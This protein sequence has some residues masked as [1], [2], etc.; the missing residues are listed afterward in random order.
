PAL[1]VPILG[2]AVWWVDFK[3][4]FSLSEGW[5]NVLILLVTILN[6]GKLIQVP[7]TFLA[8][9]IANILI[10]VQL[11]L[12][13]RKKD[14][15]VLYHILTL[16]FVNGGVA[17]VFH[18][19]SIFAPLLL[20]FLFSVIVAISLIFLQQENRY[21]QNNA[22]LKPAFGGGEKIERVT[23][24]HL[25]VLAART[26]VGF[27]LMLVLGYRWKRWIERGRRSKDKSPSAKPTAEP[28]VSK[29]ATR[30]PLVGQAPNF[31][32]A[33]APS[34]RL[35]VSVRY[36][37]GLF[38]G[39]LGSLIL[40]VLIF[41]T[42]PRFPEIEIGQIRFGHDQ[43]QGT[44]A[45]VRSVSGFN[46]QVRLGEIGPSADNF[47][48]VMTIRF[49]DQE[50]DQRQVLP[51]KAFFYLRGT[52]LVRYEDRSWFA[53]TSVSD[54]PPGSGLIPHTGKWPVRGQ[55]GRPKTEG[56]QEAM[57]GPGYLFSGKKDTIGYAL[58]DRRNG[59]VREEI[60]MFPLST[61]ILFTVWP[62]FQIGRTFGR[63]EDGRVVSVSRDPNRQI[64][65]TYYTNAFSSEGQIDL[66]PYQEETDRLLE[67]A[68]SYDAEKFPALS[69]LAVRWDQQSGLSTEQVV[70]RAKNLEYLLRSSGEYRYVRSGVQ[71][72]AD[73]DPL[74]DFATVHRQGHCEYFAG[75][76]ALMLRA[77]GIPSRVIVGF[78]SQY[79][80][81]SE[82][83]STVR[84]SD[85]HTWVEAYIP[86]SAIPEGTYDPT[87]EQE[88]QWWSQGGWLRLDAVPAAESMKTVRSLAVRWGTFRDSFRSFWNDCILNY[89]HERQSRLV[90]QPAGD[91]FLFLREKAAQITKNWHWPTFLKGD[92]TGKIAA[93]NIRA[94]STSGW[95]IPVSL[96]RMAVIVSV[97][98]LAALGG[99][100]YRR[101]TRGDIASREASVLLAHLESTLARWGTRRKK[102]Q[103][104]REFLDRFLSSDEGVKFCRFCNEAVSLS[105]PEERLSAVVRL[106]YHVRFGGNPLDEARRAEVADFFRQVNRR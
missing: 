64:R 35:C 66:I 58:F 74:E 53:P 21:Y 55:R 101:R 47:D 4:K 75:A 29:R 79:S 23:V 1:A 33:S 82:G 15:L 84:Q 42:L 11:I 52:A 18:N 37:F 40:G 106:Y 56:F 51:E 50:D 46:E 8:Y 100:W 54:N 83:F 22:F 78:M 80:P 2:A 98:S 87:L 43:W 24:G 14:I 48:K 94:K 91:L 89:N 49:S 27:P 104:P 96:T 10:W 97:V 71:R 70:Q 25:A 41:L 17:S 63:L 69:E 61:P 72:K 36:V 13:Y 81:D 20:A 5:A 85:A 57:K 45:A 38:F 67:Q 34:S 62:Y 26:V 92:E 60:N 31:S 73:I 103:T 28:I 99:L 88:R 39:A 90:Y 65:A 12:F 93:R 6:M 44:P 30:M 16:S 3:E 76:L 105:D 77:V 68:I 59:I 95:G 102:T 86:P 19:T 32:T 9:S 7:S